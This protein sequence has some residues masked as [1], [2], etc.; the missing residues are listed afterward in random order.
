MD[1]RWSV[2]ASFSKEKEKGTTF[3]FFSRGNEKRRL[4]LIKY[5]ISYF[6]CYLFFSVTDSHLIKNISVTFLLLS[7]RL[8]YGRLVVLLVAFK[9]ISTHGLLYAEDIFLFYSFVNGESLESFVDLLVWF[10]FH[11]H[12]CKLFN[13]KSCQVGYG[14]RI[15]WLHFCR[16]VKFSQQES[17]IWH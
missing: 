5:F 11:I 15:H 14:C 16:G 8:I 7:T 6:F 3:H 1:L 17:Q 10:S 4:K 13:A 2:L 12:P 9:G